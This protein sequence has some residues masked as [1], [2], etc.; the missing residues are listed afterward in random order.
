MRV[1]PNPWLA[2]QRRPASG[3]GSPHPGD[4]PVQN[5]SPSRRYGNRII[6]THM[7]PDMVARAGEAPEEC[8]CDKDGGGGMKG[9]SVR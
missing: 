5:W 7:S 3:D 8:G 4:M 2:L 1:L 6:P 9:Q